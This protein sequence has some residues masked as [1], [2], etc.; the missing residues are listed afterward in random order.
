VRRWRRHY[1][2]SFRPRPRLGG[3]ISGV[4]ER[5]AKVGSPRSSALVEVLVL[6]ESCTG[7]HGCLTSRALHLTV[8][9]ACFCVTS[10]AAVGAEVVRLMDLG[11][12]AV[13]SSGPTPWRHG[14]VPCQRTSTA[15]FCCIFFKAFMR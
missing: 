6:V 7:V 11:A 15:G 4:S 12:L 10:E 9:A 8:T 14:C 2:K 13:A 1:N 5:S 3:T